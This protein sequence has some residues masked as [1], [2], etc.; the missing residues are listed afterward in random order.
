MS[1]IAD[2]PNLALAKKMNVAAWVVAIAVLGLV[3]LM[4]EVKIPLPD[5]MSFGFLPPIH[6]TLNALTAI[7]L[8]YALYQIKQRNVEAHRKAI[9][10]AFTFSFLFLL[11][12]V[13]YHFTSYEVK[14]G[15]TNLDGVVD[16]AELAAVG[17]M[18]TIYLVLLLSHIL[19][20][21]IS[22]PFILFTFVRGFTGQYARHRKMA[23][24]VFPLWLYVAIT[25]PIV[26]WMLQPYYP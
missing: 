5:G 14:Y 17:S 15:D 21:A 18:R 8:I 25:G 6:A 26:Y 9:Y 22:F 13:A 11:S 3:A 20:A 10:V 12:Y 2:Q 23:R 24:W 7:V 16:A 1:K 4:R 19:L